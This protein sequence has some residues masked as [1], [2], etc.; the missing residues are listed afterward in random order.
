[1]S[2]TKERFVVPQRLVAPYM[3]LQR[4]ARD[5]LLEAS[6]F[7]FPATDRGTASEPSMVHE[8]SGL[9]FPMNGDAE[10]SAADAYIARNGKLK[11]AIELG[12]EIQ[13]AIAEH[14]LQPMVS[15]QS[16]T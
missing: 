15:S 4:S 10:R 5:L 3:L 13:R 6:G 11:K 2:S 16:K 9:L 14:H 7:H 12:E 8:H 1:M